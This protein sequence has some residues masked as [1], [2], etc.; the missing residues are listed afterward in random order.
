MNPSQ[1]SDGSGFPICSFRRPGTG[2]F[3]GLVYQLAGF[4]FDAHLRPFLISRSRKQKC[5]GHK[6]E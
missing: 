4:E 6:H 1:V 5:S 2:R 3:P